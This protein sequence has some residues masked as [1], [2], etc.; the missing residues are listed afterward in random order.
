MKKIQLTRQ[1]FAIVDNDDYERL[2]KYKW[3]CN[4]YGYA[5]RTETYPRING[6]KRNRKKNILMHREIINCPIGK[7]TDHKDMDKL[8][9]QKTNLRIC[10]RRMNNANLPK[11]KNCSSKYKG[12][13]WNKQIKRW[14]AQ[15]VDE[16]SQHLH[17]GTFL[18]EEDAANAYNQKARELFGEFAR[19]NE[20]SSTKLELSRGR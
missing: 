15:T 3:F 7:D 19:V 16:N 8:N 13:S 4:F 10:N 11:R 12:V 6:E 17:L 18:K 14:I 5:C 1:C 9:N 2:N 20:L